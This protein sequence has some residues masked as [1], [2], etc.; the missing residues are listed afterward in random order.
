MDNYYSS[1]QLF[2]DLYDQNINAVGTVRSSRRGFP[3]AQLFT[4]A[5]I[6]NGGESKYVANGPPLACSW[7]DKRTIHFLSTLHPG[8]LPPGNSPPTVKRRLAASKKF[9]SSSLD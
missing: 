3:A 5:S 9:V 1:P 2:A 4:K 8:N 6:S 7:V